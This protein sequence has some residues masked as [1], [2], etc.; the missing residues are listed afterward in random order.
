MRN[1]NN[2]PVGT[3]RHHVFKQG[4]LRH[5]VERRSRFV[6]YDKG[7]VPGK[8]ARQRDFLRF[9]AGQYHTAVIKFPCQHAVHTVRHLLHALQHTALPQSLG[10]DRTV[11]LPLDG[12]VRKRAA[13]D[14]CRD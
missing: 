14:I 12:I 13:Q 4:V 11:M 10:H 6:Q 7:C 8:Y 3:R 2:C 5:G 9:A 1:E